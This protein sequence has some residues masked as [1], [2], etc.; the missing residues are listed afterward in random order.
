M[1][2]VITD[3]TCDIPDP[4]LRD[5]GIEV[6]PQ[7]VIWGD[8][9][10]RDRLDIEPAAFYQRLST[11]VEKPRSS[12]PGVTDF[13]QAYERAANNGAD[14]LVVV[15]ISRTLSGTYENA[16]RAAQDFSLPVTVVDSTGTSMGM[17]W[18]V[19]AAARAARSGMDTR[20]ILEKI[21][22]VR[23]RITQIAGLDTLEYLNKGGRIGAAVKWAGTMLKVKPLVAFNVLTNLVEPVGLVRTYT[24]MVETLYRKFFERVKG[25]ANLRVAVLHGGARAH[26]EALAERVRAEYHPLELFVNSTGPVVGL[27]TGPGALGLCGYMDE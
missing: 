14:E 15:T 22:H 20:G 10:Y 25:I 11:E 2:A 17:G 12:Q 21:D 16:M 6:V 19:L 24:S 5:L 1:I 18:Q 9:Q 13:Q 3:S 8:K 4:L 7:Y 26:A 23:R 27:H